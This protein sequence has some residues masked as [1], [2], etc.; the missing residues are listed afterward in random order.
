MGI[1]AVV[2][3]ANNAIGIGV[4]VA[5]DAVSVVKTDAIGAVLINAVDAVAAVRIDGV[6]TVGINAVAAVGIDAVAR[7]EATDLGS[8]S[9]MSTSMNC[10]ISPPPQPPP[11][12]LSSSLI[13]SSP[14][15]HTGH[16]HCPIFIVHMF[17]SK[18]FAV[19]DTLFLLIQVQHQD[20]HHDL[21]HLSF[22]VH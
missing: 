16:K 22:Q 21:I 5:D 15:G 20:L 17:R 6:A 9:S 19:Y 10:S 2:A 11:P 1:D 4:V 12:S 3:D 8:S 18:V 14:T 7:V 13:G